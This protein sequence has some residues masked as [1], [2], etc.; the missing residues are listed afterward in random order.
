M[1][2][3]PGT[4]RTLRATFAARSA[5]ARFERARRGHARIGR[6]RLH[7]ALAA[8]AARSAL[9]LTLALT[10][11]ALAAPA[12]RAAARLELAGWPLARAEAEALASPALRA[13]G[14]SL[15]AATAA[16]RLAMRLQD[17]GWLDARIAAAWSTANEPAWRVTVTPGARRR[18]SAIELIAPAADSAALASRLGLHAGE[19]ASASALRAAMARTIDAAD[20]DGHAWASLTLTAWDEDSAGVHVRLAGTLGPRVIVDELRLEGLAVT[21]VDVAE[22][23]MGRL[24]GLPYNPSSARAATQRLEQLGVFERVEY[25]GLAGGGDWS[26]G[27]L[28]WRVVEPRYNRFEGAVGV[29]G[30]GTVVGLATLELG[31]LLGSARSTSLSWQSRGKGRTDFGARYVEP[32]LFGRALRWEGALQQQIQDTVFTRFRV[33]MRARVALGARDRIEAAFDQEHVVQPHADVRDA[34]AQNTSFAIEH[35]GR[36][37]ARTPRRGALG[38]I[39]ATQ[40]FSRRTLRPVGGEPAVKADVS[41]AAGR[42]EGEAHWPLGRS[43]GVALEARAAGRFDGRRVLGEWERSPVGGSASLRGHDEEEYRVDRF[44]LTRL[45]WRWFLG[46]PGQ[47]IAL[48]WDH[49]TMETRLAADSTGASRLRRE[50]AD[51]VGVGLRLPAAGG[52]VDLDYGLAPGR[53]FLEGKIHLRLVTAF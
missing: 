31:N 29:Q 45:E 42:F 51:G 17:Q 46:A 10:F 36:D 6:A 18:W 2:A 49:A 37:D 12:A 5:R 14:D 11:L 53:G 39:E 40:S 44:A 41:G 3:H 28:D 32:M 35:D 47:R 21:R 34:D 48:F 23:A 50:S 26:R 24:R 1:C 43:A 9:A 15:A 30:R 27:V 13:P 52:D 4:G 16:A 7:C 33:G 19:P 25:R 38:R 8:L 20:A 22:K